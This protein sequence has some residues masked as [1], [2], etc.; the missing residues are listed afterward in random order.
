MKFNV[1]T[2]AMSAAILLSGLTACD[3]SVKKELD[4]YNAPA[5]KIVR[6]GKSEDFSVW[7]K[8]EDK[9]LDLQD[10]FDFKESGAAKVEITSTCRRETKSIEKS[11]TFDSPDFIKLYAL[12]P[13]E[14]LAQNFDNLVDCSFI[15]KLSNG[16]GSKHI[17]DVPSYVIKD[18]KSS[19]ISIAIGADQFT[20]SSQGLSIPK[21]GLK[22]AILYYGNRTQAVAQLIC[23]DVTLPV[24]PFN[25][26]INLT[27]FNQ[28]RG[29]LREGEEEFKLRKN[30]VQEC[31][32]VI[33]QDLKPVAISPLF[34]ME[35]M[36]D[37]FSIVENGLQLRA[38]EMLED[39]WGTFMTPNID[40]T[41]SSYTLSNDDD[42]D[43]TVTIPASRIM[44]R[45]HT[46]INGKAMYRE[47]GWMELKILPNTG[48][49][50]TGNDSNYF[51]SMKPGS[52]VTVEIKLVLS[53]TPFCF[54]DNGQ[55]PNLT[56]I[57]VFA[58]NNI[59]FTETWAG[60]EEATK[61]ELNLSKGVVLP[62]RDTYSLPAQGLI[63]LPEEF[64]NL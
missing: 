51:I 59:A 3:K 52:K 43:H 21:Q 36:F 38:G 40:F 55:L 60:N 47:G 27:A 7:S 30:P 34:K 46:Y 31:R 8:A 37:G 62:R 22:E 33:R 45:T 20:L 11:V 39:A 15:L 26:G 6:D 2:S 42:L 57:A 56:G 48:I 4:V 1:L 64:C 41:Y 44:T 29:I 54:Y 16:A 24:L 10:S 50:V 23:K 5:P 28:R 61:W 53:S 12:I 9:Q 25:E 49:A 18:Q 17:F 19:E 63:G 58:R 35:F 13:D 14:I 32:A